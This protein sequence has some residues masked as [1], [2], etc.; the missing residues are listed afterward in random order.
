MNS[1]H[2]GLCACKQLSNRVVD[3]SWALFDLTVPLPRSRAHKNVAMIPTCVS[4]A[5]C[6][7]AVGDVRIDVRLCRIN[8]RNGT[9][10]MIHLGGDNYMQLPI[11]MNSQLRCSVSHLV[12]LFQND[13]DVRNSYV[14]RPQKR[15]RGNHMR[16]DVASR[17]TRMSSCDIS[18]KMH[19]CE[20]LV[21]K[22]YVMGDHQNVVF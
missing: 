2:V 1:A 6:D 4:A 19:P 8:H 20:G 17:H 14:N 5:W 21:P 13:V 12:I 15:G 7:Y 9:V 3:M 10:G 22:K 16:N 11:Q 18:V